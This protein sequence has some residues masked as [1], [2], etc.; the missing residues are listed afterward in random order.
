MLTGSSAADAHRLGLQGGDAVE[1]YVSS[2]SL[3]RIVDEHALEADSLSEGGNV[4]L[5]AM[6]D[7]VWK[8]V[9]RKVAPLAAVLVDLS[10]SDDPRS[11][12]VGLA[13]LDSL[14]GGRE[15]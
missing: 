15:P 12:R 3:A 5:R 10:E 14:D 6:P 13:G 7:D 1:A 11:R 2:D 9:Q 4:L 8:R